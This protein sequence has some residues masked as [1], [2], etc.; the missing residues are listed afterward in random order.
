MTP[1]RIIA[2]VLA[3]TPL[4]LL[5]ACPGKSATTSMTQAQ[6]VQY[7]NTHPG[8][9]TATINRCG[10]LD[11]AAQAND[12]DCAAALYSSLYGPSQLKAT[13]SP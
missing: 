8:E 4:A 9:R 2:Y 11:Q 10:A 5:T 1:T 13:A 3:L 12:P 6:R 7:Y